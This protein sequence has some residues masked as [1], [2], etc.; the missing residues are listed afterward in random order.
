VEDGRIRALY[1]S[2]RELRDLASGLEW[3]VIEAVFERHADVWIVKATTLHK[4]RERRPP[5]DR[6]DRVEVAG[7]INQ[8]A[9]GVEAA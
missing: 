7:V 9:M 4:R 8:L 6:R 5:L 3:L 1:G 2:G